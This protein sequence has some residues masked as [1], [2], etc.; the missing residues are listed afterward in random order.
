MVSFTGAAVAGL[1][2]RAEFAQM[3]SSVNNTWSI[4]GTPQHQPLPHWLTNNPMP[5][6]RPWGG[7]DS[8]NTNYYKDTPETGMTR[9]Y[10]WS[11]AKLQCAPDGVETTCLAA[12]GQIPGPLITAN[13]GDW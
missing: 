13:W 8:W 10:E 4:L 7:R 9:Y 6:G 12:N 5:Q 2:S 1:A 11:V 3:S